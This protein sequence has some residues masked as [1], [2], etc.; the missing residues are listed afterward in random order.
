MVYVLISFRNG[1]YVNS[2]VYND[3]NSAESARNYFIDCN[4]EFCISGMNYV[5]EETILMG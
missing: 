2:Y 4:E 1:E 3:R 5:I